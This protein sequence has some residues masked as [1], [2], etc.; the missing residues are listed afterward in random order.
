MPLL[1]LPEYGIWAVSEDAAKLFVAVKDHV[2]LVAA[3]AMQAAVVLLAAAKKDQ[4]LAEIAAIV[5][6]MDLVPAAAKN[7]ND[8]FSWIF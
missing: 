8:F 5:I 6:K 7:K 3:T 2:V 4:D 1:A